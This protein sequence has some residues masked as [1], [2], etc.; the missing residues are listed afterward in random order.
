MKKIILPILLLFIALTDVLSQL[1]S[2]TVNPCDTKPYIE[3]TGSAEMEIVPDEIYIQV[4]LQERYNGKEKITMEKQDALFITGMQSLNIDSKGISLA[5]AQSDFSSYKWKKEDALARKSYV[6][7]V[8][9]AA[10]VSKVYAKLVEIDAEDAYILK[11]SHSK[12]EEYRKQIKINAMIATK[13]KAGYL[14]SSIGEEVGS[15]I[16]IQERETYDSPYTI[17]QRSLAS[18][19]AFE[20][21]NLNASDIGFKKIKLR[22]EIFAQFEIK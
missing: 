17:S 10:L 16:L 20:A 8:H 13:D 21:Y 22:Y 9:D 11:T 7:L 4:T 14:L 12:I 2:S 6:V 3:V 5:D 19:V 18:N 15:P 1:P